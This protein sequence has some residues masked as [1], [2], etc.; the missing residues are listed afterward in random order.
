M[1]FV[2]GD[3]VRLFYGESYVLPLEIA[4]ILAV[5]FYTIG[6]LHAS[7]TYKSTL[8]LFK[9][10]QYILIFTGIINLVLDVILGSKFGVFG[11]YAATLVARLC[12]NLWY[13]P[14]AVYRYGLK[15]NPFLYLIRYGIFTAV[16]AMA[17]GLCYLLCNM[18]SFS[19]GINIL[20]KCVICTVVPNALFVLC[21]MKTR[22]FQYLKDRAKSI[23]MRIFKKNRL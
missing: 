8:G 12:T 10:G 18:C 2:S 11:I 22:E 15:K 19:I 9:Y 1:A 16:L 5:N 17:G 4:L 20:V 13:E 23:L 7:Y 3:L 21:F 14:Y 6:M